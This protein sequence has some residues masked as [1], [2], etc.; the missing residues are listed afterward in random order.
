MGP[1]ALV[2]RVLREFRERLGTLYG[3]RLRNVVLFGSYAREDAEEG[4]DIDLLVVLDDF[5]DAE[6]EHAR[7]SPIAAQVSL[8]HDVLISCMVYRESE[9][10]RWNT[11]LLLNVRKEGVL[12]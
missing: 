9:Y 6:A 4:S 1:N 3:P 7:V 12:V 5:D 8:E 10:H 11:P 2:R